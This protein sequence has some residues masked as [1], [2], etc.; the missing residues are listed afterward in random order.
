MAKPVGIAAQVATEPADDFGEWIFWDWLRISEHSHDVWI[1]P[2]SVEGHDRLSV[3]PFPK[4][5]PE[6]PCPARLIG[7]MI[8]HQSTKGWPRPP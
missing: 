7:L 3:A 2:I 1:N 6:N 4:V 8:L 5:Q